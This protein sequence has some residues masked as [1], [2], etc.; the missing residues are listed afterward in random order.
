MENVY[1]VSKNKIGTDCDSGHELPI[2][3]FRLKKTV[4][5]TT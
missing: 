4:W 5:K 2:T 1:T 3:K